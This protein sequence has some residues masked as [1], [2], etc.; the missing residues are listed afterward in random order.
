MGDEVVYWAQGY[1]KYLD[2]VETK[3]VYPIPKKTK[4]WE[5]PDKRVCNFFKLTSP[6]SL[7]FNFTFIYF[8]IMSLSKL[9]ALNMK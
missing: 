8:R 9:L 4:A 1:K 7:L 3:D 5:R 6:L 2:A